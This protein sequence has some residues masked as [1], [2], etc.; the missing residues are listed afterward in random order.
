[1]QL[2]FS[3]VCRLIV[4]KFSFLDVLTW[5]ITPRLYYTEYFAFCKGYLS[6]VQFLVER[7]GEYYEEIFIF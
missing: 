6:L 2:F 5:Q 7:K 3:R 4:L 1:M